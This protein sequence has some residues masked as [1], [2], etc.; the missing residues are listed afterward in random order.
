MDLLKNDQ[1]VKALSATTIAFL[2]DKYYYEVK[3]TQGSL[4]YAT[5]VGL[6][7]FIGNYLAT[8]TPE[9]YDLGQLTE[10]KSIDFRIMEV[11]YASLS[12]YILNDKVIQNKF[13][14][15]PGEA[16]LQIALYDIASEYITDYIMGNNISYL[17][18]TN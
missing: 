8:Q 15:K 14:S 18:N 13:Y 4:M 12:S 3:N 9:M 17:D 6:S 10:N 16:I 11:A 5:G 2:L 1:I 7:M